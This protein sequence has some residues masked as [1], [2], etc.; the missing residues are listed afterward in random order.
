MGLLDRYYQWRTRK[1]LKRIVQT[2]GKNIASTLNGGRQTMERWDRQLGLYGKKRINRQ[3]I[4]SKDVM[5]SLRF[6]R[7]MNPDASMAIWNFM[8][9]ANT[10]HELE[11][12]KKGG[13]ADKQGLEYLEELSSRVG[14]L[15]GGGTDQLINVLNLTAFTQGAIALEVELTEGL[16]DVVDFHAIDPSTLDFQVDK[17]GEVVLTQKQDKGEDVV[18]N[19]EQVFYI[20]LD[21]DIGDPYGRSPILP[22]LQVVFF[23]VEVLR[24]LKAVA[25]NQGHARFDVKILEESIMQNIPPAV[26][27]QGAPAVLKFVQDYIASVQKE[28]SMLKPDDNLFHLDNVEVGMVG[29]TNGK[30]MDFTALVNI[31]NQQVVTSLKQLPMLLGRNEGTTETHG[32]VQWQI[33]VAGIQSIQRLNKRVLERAYNVAL[34][35]KGRQAKAKLTFDE[36]RTTDRYQDAQSEQMEANTWA[37][38]RD[39]G[40][41]DNNEASNAMV[42]HDAVDEPKPVAQPIATNG[43]EEEP[44]ERKAR[45]GKFLPA[46]R[47]DEF[48]SGIKEEWADDASIITDRAKGEIQRLLTREKRQIISRLK[49]AD[50]PPTRALVEGWRRTRAEE[51]VPEE[52]PTT[53]TAWVQ[54]Y[55]LLETGAQI[56]AWTD[57]L[58]QFMTATATLAGQASLLSLNLDMQFNAQDENLLRA[59]SDRARADA[60]L[61]Q[62]TTDSD[63]IMTL[64]DVVAEGNYS[65]ARAVEALEASHTFNASRAETIAR[66]EIIGASRTGQYEG[67]RQSGIVIGKQWFSAHQDRTRHGHREADGQIV[68]FDEPFIVDNAQGSGEELMFPGDA[69]RGAT[70]SNIINCRCGY[71]RILEGD[72]DKLNRRSDET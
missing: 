22:F 49:N 47:K 19:Q 1:Q 32:T 34:Q 54:A 72:E 46:S 5:D 40:W 2:A 28:F 11:V 41:V 60:N 62:G 31:L 58:L 57:S 65:V 7:D 21:P 3:E 6:I 61:I 56:Q 4:R 13:G 68:A 55:L 8:R 12:L 48:V 71:F 15:Y 50:A 45:L 35:I 37:F 29:G 10:G 20:P 52:P 25:H 14:K 39:Q 24:D 43:E 9:L 70:A 67:D 23:Q 16:D 53:F 36:L 51:E 17:D 59:L 30:S 63:V 38:K 66:T 42:G 18:L 44:E 26:Q 64:W 27:S 33:F 69:S